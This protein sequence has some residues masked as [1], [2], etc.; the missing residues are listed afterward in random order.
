MPS[1]P[2]ESYLPIDIRGLL[3][4]KLFKVTLGLQGEQSFL[5][6]QVLY[7]IVYLPM[8]NEVSIF[9]ALGNII[10]TVQVTHDKSA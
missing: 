6:I 3:S 5:R 8:F 7:P 1:L 4:M 10:G 9:W 2:L